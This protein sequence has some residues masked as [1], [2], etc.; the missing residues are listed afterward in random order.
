MPRVPAK[1]T[2]ELAHTWIRYA[3]PV[4]PFDNFLLLH[5]VN[6]D[7]LSNPRLIIEFGR[8]LIK[9]EQWGGGGVAHSPGPLGLGRRSAV[10]GEETQ[11]TKR[12]YGFRYFCGFDVIRR[13][14]SWEERSEER[15]KNRPRG[16]DA[17]LWGG[18]GRERVV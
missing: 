1:R 13:T 14:W 7:R 9:V 11:T 12:T 4:C 2:P 18:G 15:K 3:H 17:Y 6:L 10:R 5:H 8:D 16:I